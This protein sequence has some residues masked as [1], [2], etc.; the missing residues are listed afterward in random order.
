MVPPIDFTRDTNMDRFFRFLADTY[1]DLFATDPDYA[2]AASH[3]TPEDL[4]R[5]MT[6]GL[7]AGTAS[8]DGSGIR[9][10]CSHFKISYTYKAIRAFLEA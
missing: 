4:A 9:R 2:Y 1:R 7:S 6:I 3:T 8:K 10:A 5:R